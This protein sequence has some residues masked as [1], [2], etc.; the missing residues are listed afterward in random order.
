[1]CSGAAK[2][3]KPT[4]N[5]SGGRRRPTS[6]WRENT[7]RPMAPRVAVRAPA[8][9]A[10]RVRAPSSSPTSRAAASASCPRAR[11]SPAIRSAASAW[12]TTCRDMPCSPSPMRSARSPARFT[13]SAVC[14]AAPAP[15][16]S[17][18]WDWANPSSISPSRDRR[19]PRDPSILRAMSWVDRARFPTSR[20]TTEKPRPASPARGRLDG[21]VEGQASGSAGSPCRSGKGT[22]PPPSTA[23]RSPWVR[24]SSDEATRCS[25]PS[26]SSRIR[27]SSMAARISERA[28]PSSSARTRARSP[29][30]APSRDRSDTSRATPPIRGAWEASRSRAPRTRALRD[31]AALACSF[32]T[33]R[34]CWSF[35]PNFS[36]ASRI[37]PDRPPRSDATSQ[38]PLS[39]PLRG[40]GV[41][42]ALF[43]SGGP[44][45]HYSA[46]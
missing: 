26:S 8:D 18:S 3:V 24:A 11:V 21:R 20:A 15:R 31:S 38:P 30:A 37:T 34:V 32:P 22:P 2:G 33:H 7:S 12:I 27:I 14:R 36:A 29:R 10:S 17:P 1:M 19:S 43:R 23:A 4:Q 9:S 35:I 46:L 41:E 40:H 39:L 16:R 6:V 5:S 44:S 25:S 28:R 42:S 13:V 45:M